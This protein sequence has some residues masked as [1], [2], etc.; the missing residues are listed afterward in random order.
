ML[1]EIGMGIGVAG[2]DIS[3]SGDVIGLGCDITNREAVK[4]ALQQLLIA[5]GGLD[6]VTVTA[7]LYPTPDEDGRVPDKAW[8]QSFAVN[9]KGS[10]IVADEASSIWQKQGLNGSMVVTT[11]A[12]AVV[13]KSGSLAYDTSKAAANHLV[14]ELSI[15]LAPNIRVNGVAPATVVEGSSMFPRDRVKASLTKYGIDFKDDE[16]TEV[17]RD[18]L[19]EFYAQRTLTKRPISLDQQTEAIYRL[20]SSDFENT[21]GHIIP[22]DGGLTEA[23]LR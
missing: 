15:S 22:V 1:N 7:G 20:L 9:V 12:N 5:Y 6:H 4:D 2:S 8:D 10:Y 23:F 14:R 13:P 21:T 11:S 19:A 17:L 18:R 3:G 16:E